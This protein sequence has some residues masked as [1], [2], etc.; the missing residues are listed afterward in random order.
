MFFH[1]PTGFFHN[2]TDFWTTG[3]VSTYYPSTSIKH[4]GYKIMGNVIINGRSVAH[5]G[6]DGTLQTVDICKTPPD[7]NAVVY[8]NIAKTADLV[9]TCPSIKINGFEV[10]NIGSIIAVSSGDE[11]GTCGGV[12]SGTIKG[13]AE[14]LTGSPNVFFEGL[15][16]LRQGDLGV[17][18]NRNTPPAPLMQAGGGKPPE[19]S[20]E[21]PEALEGSEAYSYGISTSGDDI[22]M[23]SGLFDIADE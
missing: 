15:P 1:H 14:F 10:A 22:H 8:T 6:S 20:D 5:V 4:G 9:K 3:I 19:I 13:P 21:D 11:A 16:A 18:N 12:I 17:S 7:C 23:Q 2:L